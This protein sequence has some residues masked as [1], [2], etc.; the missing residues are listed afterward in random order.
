MPREDLQACPRGETN[1]GDKRIPKPGAIDIVLSGVTNQFS[2][3]LITPQEA[4]QNRSLDPRAWPE[5]FWRRGPRTFRRRLDEISNKPPAEPAR[6]DFLRPR[7][8]FPNEGI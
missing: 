2:K 4:L 1:E 5:L 8:R 6:S 7:G 3:G